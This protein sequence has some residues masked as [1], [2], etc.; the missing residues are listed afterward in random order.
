[1][2][3]PPGESFSL[4]GADVR[5]YGVCVLLAYL[6]WIGVTMRMWHRGGG[7]AIDAGWAC[8]LAAP[9]AYLG[10]RLYH[11]VT[12]YDVYR[13]DPTQAFDVTKGGLGIFGA[14]LGGFLALVI[15]ANARRWPVGT[16]LD[17][18]I[19]G[20]PLAQAIGRIGNWFNQEL[21]GGP[22][23][24]PWGLFVDPQYR[25]ADYVDVARYHPLFL[26]EAT[27]D[28]MVFVALGV[29]WRPLHARFRP[30]CVVAMY[31]I[32]YGLIRLV[33][34]GMR[35]EPAVMAGPFRLNQVVAF[36]VM[37]TGLLVLVLLDKRRRQEA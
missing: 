26:Y 16:F 8:L 33:I 31:L 4:V 5:W 14:I 12:D 11:V 37:A 36:L 23:D 30:G 13:G 9:V 29:L 20:I 19:V 7:D 35:I 25:L 22:T 21:Y 34:E 15:Y 6:V 18:A 32:L 28:V 1:M 27:L 2:P 3:A 10:A 17:C 24:L